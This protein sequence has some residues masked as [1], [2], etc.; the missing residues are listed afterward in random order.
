MNTMNKLQQAIHGRFR[1]EDVLK[2]VLD[3][4]GLNLSV[5]VRADIKKH[6]NPQ[7]PTYMSTEYR[8]ASDMA[9][10]LRV[11]ADLFPQ[12]QPVPA[13]SDTMAIKVYIETLKGLLGMDALDFKSRPNRQKRLANAALPYASHYAYNKRARLIIRM[14]DKFERVQHALNLFSLE[15][16]AKTKLAYQLIKEDVTHPA[17]LAFLAYFVSRMGLRSAF[18]VTSQV[19]AFDEVSEKLFA[20]CLQD[21]D[22]NWLQIAHVFDSKEV[23]EKL[24]DT[25]KGELLGKFYEVMA[26]GAKFLKDLDAA[27]DYDHENLIVRRGNDSSTWNAAA[28]AYNKARDA[29][30]ALLFD[31]KQEA[32]LDIICPGKALRLM[33]ADVVRWHSLTGGAVEPNTGV[34]RLLPRPWL[35][36]LGKESCTRADIE[37]ALTAVSADDKTRQGWVKQRGNIHVEK[38]K[39]T[40]DMVHGISIASPSL[41]LALRKAGVFS[42]QKIKK[43]HE[44]VVEAS[45]A[46][47]DAARP[48]VVVP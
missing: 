3:L 15:Q 5:R 17:T 1:P 4:Q 6:A 14:A 42:G 12:V 46:L 11:A 48:T 33:A 25:Q 41:A 7:Y 19:K 27:G 43:G 26:L 37:L 29:W 39:P 31:L 23:L 36:V 8:E 38:T 32:L 35:I 45:A 44:D 18:T 22:T 24:T 2:D 47:I 30:I 20:V 21:P 10:Q 13:L 16:S 40:A 9:H 28:G 34:Y